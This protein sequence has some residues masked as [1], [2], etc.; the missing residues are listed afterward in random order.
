[1]LH[2][3]DVMARRREKKDFYS[4]LRKYTIEKALARNKQSLSLV[5]NVAKRGRYFCPILVLFSIERKYHFTVDYFRE[6]YQIR[7]KIIEILKINFY[8]I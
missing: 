5:T 6:K 7:T 4:L 3:S 1:M 2:K 8:E